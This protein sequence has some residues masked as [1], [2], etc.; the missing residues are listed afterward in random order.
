MNGM[1]RSAVRRSARGSRLILEMLKN[2]AILLSI[3]LSIIAWVSF[4]PR[5]RVYISCTEAQP[6]TQEIPDF[7]PGEALVELKSFSL[8]HPYN[9]ANKLNQD[10]F[11]HTRGFVLQV[12]N[13]GGI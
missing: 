6:L 9:G 12:R 11:K 10:A 7:L 5:E 1:P 4:G 13:H 2:V 3:L 8:S